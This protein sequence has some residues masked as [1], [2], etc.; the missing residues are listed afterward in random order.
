MTLY[1]KNTFHS[2]ARLS[3][4]VSAAREEEGGEEEGSVTPPSPIKVY[5]QAR[6][7]APGAQSGLKR[8][9]F[10]PV[11]RI[12]RKTNLKNPKPLSL[13]NTPSLSPLSLSPST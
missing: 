7:V 6:K 2:A 8:G 3:V 13:K 5:K 11:D 1:L 4:S 12:R 9:A 10:V